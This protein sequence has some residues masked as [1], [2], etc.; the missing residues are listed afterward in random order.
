MG[1]IGSGLDRGPYAWPAAT[2][3]PQPRVA[4][5]HHFN[6][7]DERIRKLQTLSETQHA[8]YAQF[9]G[10][11]YHVSTDQFV[12]EEGTTVRQR[13]M[14]KVYGLL[15]VVIG[16]LAKGNEGAEWIQ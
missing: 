15:Q 8:R 13:Q 3:L 1:R 5:F 4:I 2:R 12:P 10:Y 6:L 9:W 11:D 7:H 14:N 16:E